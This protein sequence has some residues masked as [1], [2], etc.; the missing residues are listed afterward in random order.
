MDDEAPNVIDD[1][2]NDLTQKIVPEQI[3][4]ASWL[5]PFGPDAVPKVSEPMGEDRWLM[6]T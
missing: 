1:T 5:M 3:A 4:K 2:V 6:A